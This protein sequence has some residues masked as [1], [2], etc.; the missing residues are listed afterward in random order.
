MAIQFTAHD[1]KY[2]SIDSENIDWLSVTSFVKL[3]K[4]PFDQQAIA[5]RSSKSRKSK[6]YGMKP[7]DILKAWNNETVRA[8]SLGSWYHDQRE[9][10]VIMCDN[11]TRSG[12]ALPIIRP[13]EQDGVKLAPDQNL[14]DGIYPEHMMYL[15]SAA[16]CGQADRVEV[17]QGVIDLYDYKTNKE[18]KKESSVWK[19]ISKKMFGPCSHLDDCN[20][21]HYALQLSTYMYIMTKH[22]YQ[23]TPGKMQ[24]H[25]IKF[26][27]EGEDK[28]GYPITAIDPNGDPIV[29]EVIPYDVPYLKTEVREMIKYIKAHPEVIKQGHI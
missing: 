2:T 29:H 25:H 18:I 10:E 14:T 16:L 1:H 4:E 27:I 22:N 21:N 15:K 3:F 17:I 6:W 26:K 7:E 19:G 24:I 11:I 13:L 8:V 28:Y 20:F 5:E 12:I 23:L 9:S